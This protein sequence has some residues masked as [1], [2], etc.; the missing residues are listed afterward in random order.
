M[1]FKSFHLARQSLAKGF[2]HGYAQSVV[3][4]VSQ[5]NPLASFQHDRFR[6]AGAKQN[7]HAFSTTSTTSAVKQAI[8]LLDHQDSG[9]AAYFAAWQK[10]RVDDKDWSQFQFRKLIEWKPQSSVSKTKV[11]AKDNNVAIE[12]TS[13][14]LPARAGVNRAY[15]T[16]QVDDFRKAVTDEQLEEIALA[17]VDEAITQEAAKIRAANEA[18][19]QAEQELSPAVE[20]RTE[21]PATVSDTLVDSSL[22]SR[23][24]SSITVDVAELVDEYTP[25]LQR[26]AEK[27]SY[28]DIPAVFESMLH[29]NIR[30]SVPAYNA[31]LSAAINLP[32]AKHQV[33]PKALDVY[34]DM[35]RRRVLPNTETYTALIELLSVRS[36][37]VVSMTQSLE[38][39]RLRYGGMEEEGRFMLGSNE[40]EY[41]ILSE[42]GSLGI[43]VKLFDTAITSDPSRKL[44]E[45][46]YRLL[47]TACAEGER[48]EDMVRIFAH[49]ET[50]NVTPPADVFVP[51]I[52]TF[53]KLGDLR[54]AVECYDEYKALA[55]S[56]NNG[57]VT[58]S[59][60]D[61]DVYAA[62]VKA[63][64]ICDRFEGGRKFLSKIEAGL[65][66]P[67]EV[68]I[69]RDVVNLKAFI[70]EMLKN[71]AFHQAYACAIEEISPQ[72]R[73]VAMA[74]ICIKAADKNVID[75]ATDA[76]EA[77]PAE[78]DLSRPAMA[79]GAMHIRNGNIEAAEIFWRMLELSPTKPDFVEPTAMHAI[80]LIGSGHGE[81][82]LR[83][84]RQMFARL[85]DSQVASNQAKM[86]IVEHIDEAVEVIGQFMMKRGIILPAR[87]SMELMWTMIEN[88]G[89]V[90]P[91]AHHL[92]AGMGP[93]AVSELSFKDITLLM[94]VQS[95]ILLGASEIDVA[96]AARFAHLVEVIT[97]T[98][99]PVSKST[100]NL[101]ER[102]LVKLDRGDLQH[103]WYN[104]KH[105]A[106]E[107]IYSP[108]TPYG[109]FPIQATAPAPAAPTFE[110][111]YDPYASTTDMKGSNAITELLE[112]T[113]GRSSSHLNEALM[114]FKNMRRAGRHPRFFTYAKLITAAAKED[115]LNLA[116]D[117]LNLAKQDVPLLA[118]Y[119]VVRYGWVTILDA[120]VA[121]CLTTGQRELAAQYH[122]DLLD[123]GAAPTANT[124]GLYITTLKESTKTFD[125]ATEAVK[126]FLRAK[127][128][129]VE[130]SSFLYNALIG[131][132][133]K[134]RRIDD[135]LFYFSE[136][137]NLGI[138]PTS[139]TYGTIVNALCRVSD[140][141]FAEEL[142]EEMESMPNYKP[143][144]AP[145]HSMM[146]FFLTTKR[147]RSK[148]LAYYQ[149]MVSKHIEPTTHTYKLLID[150][151]ATLDPVD[152]PAAEAILDKIRSS[153]A[154][155][156]AVHY[157]SLIHAKGCVMHDMAGARA[158]FD[159]VMADSRIRPQACLYQALF[160]S[161]VANH[162]IASTEPILE[163]M[164]RRGV[165]MTPYI[166]N[167]LIHGWALTH[168]I[169]KARAIYNAVPANKREPSTYEAMTRAYMAVEDRA[170]AMSVVNEGLSR[171]YPA[172]VA[173]KILELIGGGAAPRAPEVVAA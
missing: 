27:R 2:T 40:T 55:V 66:S 111:S 168:N 106:P 82:G 15:S 148:V 163:D 13:D 73:H 37:E 59:R 146:Q 12:E 130:P 140:E 94:Q 31:L 24:D 6:K 88:G 83:H 171:G 114:K 134:A 79:M 81:R 18:A 70:P 56:S 107:P 119:R 121:A 84:G 25:E 101:V 139:V 149:R 166:A 92:L 35:L 63:Y 129:G 19:V 51:M 90:T 103:R 154:V 108:A 11:E 48:V 110:D 80:A 71:E 53:G 39:K 49:M 33:V 96:H 91:V 138:R 50:S 93:E 87:A 162:E 41:D 122:Q 104:Y 62:L 128:E 157:S 38:E 117:I 42:D 46:T 1:V 9:L 32:R 172:A 86:E 36:L 52:Q 97:S 3:A 147:D 160:E 58:V 21:S 7:Q 8:S 34:S 120:M 26:L 64:A 105:P 165:E 5:N 141:K 23:S 78:M 169:D 20:A 173:G 142:F 137:R 44:S 167:S 10:H 43:A 57:D 72:A 102:V 30:P 69:V 67:E 60:K 109:A 118:Q 4:G 133:G 98:G 65:A 14:P 145:Y 17:Q 124:F 68:E 161:M 112:K 28:A 45:K 95:S 153:G 61:N 150:T 158:L 126:I 99:A 113:H 77:L 85:R 132:L 125:E 159:T 29:S 123:M 76:F 156:E 22:L 75:V 135:C 144:P 164:S 151:H 131:K 74:A 100:A 54:S 47:V 155:P 89:L 16:S 136:M 127:S 116:H 152:M 170:S 115:R 143:R